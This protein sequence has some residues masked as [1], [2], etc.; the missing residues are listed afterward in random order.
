MT[1][2]EDLDS[3]PKVSITEAGGLGRSATRTFGQE[4]QRS[5]RGWLCKRRGAMFYTPM[6]E[7]SDI[8][9][10]KELVPI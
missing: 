5:G 3:G 4:K 6:R 9:Y 7:M 8:H 1:I 10:D 2:I